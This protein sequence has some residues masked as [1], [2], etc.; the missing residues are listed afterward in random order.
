MFSFLPLAAI[1]YNRTLRLPF[2]ERL[3]PTVGPTT[4]LEPLNHNSVSA[5]RVY[6]RVEGSLLELTT[7]RPIGFF[8]WNAQTFTE[9]WVRRGLVLLMA[10]LRPFLYAANRKFATRAVHTVLRGISRDRL[11][12]LGEEYFQYK[13]KPYLKPDGVQALSALVNS[14]KKVV[15]VSQGL[16]HVMR[17]LAQHLG[18]KWLIANRLEFRDGMGTGRL[19]D[20]VVRPRGL[21]ARITGTGPDGSRT[22]E[23]LVHDLGLA[24]VAELQSAVV[25]AKRQAPELERPI[26]D[27]DGNGRLQPFSVRKALAGKHVM[28]IGVT[29]FI[30]KVWLVNTLMDLPEIG[31]IYLLIR[32]QKSN[33]AQQRFEKLVEESP[34]FDPLYERYGSGLLSFLQERVEVVEGDVSQPGLGLTAGKIGGAA[35]ET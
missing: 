29:G 15:L 26:V 1:V 13:L 31:K 20:P 27:F 32:R 35:K 18:V 14:G 17:P 3:G 9:R 19:L 5:D 4:N 24:D 10:L 25:A 2:Q 12:L 21:F 30:G 16:D 23:K 11:D 8:T 22:A 28:L 7:V 6:W 33:P 34:V